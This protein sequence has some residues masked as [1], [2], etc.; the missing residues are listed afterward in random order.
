M[1]ENVYCALCGHN[2][3]SRQQNDVM[4]EAIRVRRIFRCP[5]CKR[6]LVWQEW[7]L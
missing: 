7:F 3:D 2:L 5:H 1:K 6:D 4:G